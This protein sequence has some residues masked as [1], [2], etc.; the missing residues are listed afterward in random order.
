MSDLD[1]IIERLELRGHRITASRRRVLQALLEAPAHFTV[2]DVLQRLPDVGRA[3][4]FRA[5]KLLQDLNLVCRVLMEDG[6]LH[7]RL[8][9]RGH[10]H[11]LVCRSCGRVEDFATCDVSSLVE[12][13]ARSTEY[14]IEG[15]WLEV[16]GQCASCRILQRAEVKV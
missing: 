16:Y 1:L 3:T 13:L 8:S 7:Y 9:A 11:H 14:E 10:H 12:Q 6:S 15:H 5:M 2:E 4:V